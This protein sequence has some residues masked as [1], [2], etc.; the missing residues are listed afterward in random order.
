MSFSQMH[1]VV[2]HCNG[3]K[4]SGLGHFSRCFNIALALKKCRVSVTFCGLYDDFANNK[5][6]NAGFS[7]SSELNVIFGQ[8]V[9]CDD[10]N[11]GI[12]HLLA[13]DAAGGK[14]ILIDDFDQYNY[15]FIKLIVNF[16]YGAAKL[17]KVTPR[18]ALDL[19][20]FPFSEDLI[21][22]RDKTLSKNNKG[23]ISHVMVF[24]GAHDK[25]QIAARL[26]ALLDNLLLDKHIILV[27]ANKLDFEL[28]NNNLEQWSFVDD[29]A[30][31]YDWAD[32]II[33]GG[34]L[35]KYEAGFCL[36]PN[37]ALSQTKEQQED[38]NMLAK[39]NLCFD[40]GLAESISQDELSV[41][42]SQFINDSA[43][44]QLTA[45][46]SNFDRNSMKHLTKKILE[47]IHE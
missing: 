12:N 29:I 11:L 47:V 13:I 2:I 32:I 6:V 17:C 25:H 39:A 34:G 21:S 38:T 37:A 19:T 42:L 23:S 3:N 7:Y 15:D 22:V 43:T 26:L 36:K 16:R 30:Q 10:Y 20:F 27:A 8:T 31:L 1:D 5:L 9:L 28:K 46:K 33:S 44:K 35:T 14:L 45:Q 4:K 41:K 18:H 24:I 40:L